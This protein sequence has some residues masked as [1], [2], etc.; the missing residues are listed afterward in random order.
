MCC[1]SIVNSWTPQEFSRSSINLRLFCFHYA[2]GG[3]S[4]FRGW[5][6][7]LPIGIEV[8][9][10][11][12]PGRETRINEKPY[13]RILDLIPDTMNALQDLF[14]YPYALFGHSMSGLIA[15]E[16]THAINEKKLKK[17]EMLFISGRCAPHIRKCGP[18]IH[19]LSDSKFVGELCKLGGISTEILNS[20]E[21]IQLIIPLL[22]ADIELVE[23]YAHIS[24]PPLE[25]PVTVFGGLQDSEVPLSALKSWKEY[26]VKSFNYYTLPGGHFF[27][28][29]QRELLLEILHQEL[30]AIEN[31]LANH[32]S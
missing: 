21:L 20:P 19:S 27:I 26:T 7:I 18:P 29:S 24:R 9:P 3:A 22:R 12:L 17:P 25:C 2:G 14:N 5:N 13:T 23:M 32:T 16:L 1:S 8:I 10:V 31:Q 6:K 11:Q 28:N 30:T 4:L 15:Y